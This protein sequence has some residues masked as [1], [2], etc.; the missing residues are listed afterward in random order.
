VTVLII[1]IALRAAHT[2]NIFYL[3]YIRLMWLTPWRSLW[4]QPIDNT[5]HILIQ[6]LP[7]TGPR[8]LR[9]GCG[10]VR[11]LMVDVVG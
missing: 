4:G 1:M 3:E 5:I 7:P 9:R 6:K 2:L 10:A 11:P 8:R